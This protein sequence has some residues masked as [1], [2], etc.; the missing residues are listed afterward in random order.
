MTA[1]EAQSVRGLLLQRDDAYR[2]LAEQHHE[3]EHRLHELKG[4]P[5]LSTSEL[6]E[7]STLK[8]RKLAVKD[9]M[10]QI[11]RTYVTAQPSA[12]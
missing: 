1:E 12:S 4:K 10:E 7:E 8:K 2:Q 5:H 6:L 11:A 3:L 9:R